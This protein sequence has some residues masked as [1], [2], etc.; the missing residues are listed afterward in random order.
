MWSLVPLVVIVVSGV[1]I[2][3]RWAG[4]LVY[5]IA[6]DA[7]PAATP[8]PPAPAGGVAGG[9][10]GGSAVGR[11][12]ETAPQSFA[13]LDRLYQEAATRVPDWRTLGWY[14]RRAPTHRSASRSIEGPAVSRSIARRSRWIRPRGLRSRGSRSTRSLPVDARDRTFDSRT[15]AS[16]TPSSA[17]AR[18]PGHA[19]DD[20]ARLDGARARLAP[21]DPSRAHGKRARGASTRGVSDGRATRRDPYSTPLRLRRVYCSTTASAAP[22]GGTSRTTTP[23]ARISASAS[24]RDCSNSS[25]AARS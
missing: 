11:G 12:G 22:A 18:R 9:V 2:S 17:N 13:H 3:Y 20:G 21:S 8:R 25:A 6:G 19:G 24:S 1:V 10:A 15:P 5:R 7:P 16:T 4:D 23:R 14:S